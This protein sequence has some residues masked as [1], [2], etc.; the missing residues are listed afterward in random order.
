M[1]LKTALLAAAFGAAYPVVG[2]NAAPIASVSIGAP[3]TQIEDNDGG[4]MARRILRGVT[5]RGDHRDGYHDRRR[6][7]HRDNYERNYER[8]DHDED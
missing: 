1:I 5:G 6:W 2:V 3:T 8:R 4:D 7:G